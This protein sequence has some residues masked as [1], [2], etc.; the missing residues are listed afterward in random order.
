MYPRNRVSTSSAIV[1]MKTSQKQIPMFI[2]AVVLT[3]TSLTM[4]AAERTAFAFTPDFAKSQRLKDADDALVK[5]AFDLYKAGKYDEALA[6][7]AK[8]AAVSPKDFRPDY[9]SG[10]VYMA[11][12]KMKSAS[13]AFARAIAL[14]PDYKQTYLLK[15]SA[16]R[17][18]NAREESIAAARKAIELDPNFAEAYEI[19]GKYWR[20]MKLRIE[21]GELRTENGEPA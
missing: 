17:Y 4:A 20:G 16:D 7:C 2:F 13:E 11:Q 8:A 18:R 21:N 1:F 15:A 3:V 19:L 12:W 9:V 6:M 10:L 5:A 14:R